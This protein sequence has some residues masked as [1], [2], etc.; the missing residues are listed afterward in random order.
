MILHPWRGL[1]FFTEN[2]TIMSV[3]KHLRATVSQTQYIIKKK[4]QIR[5]VNLT[6]SS[7]WVAVEM[8]G[9]CLWMMTPR[10]VCLHFLFDELTKQ[11]HTRPHTKNDEQWSPH[12]WAWLPESGQWWWRSQA[13]WLNTAHPTPPASIYPSLLPTHSCHLTV[14]HDTLVCVCVCVHIRQRAGSSRGCSG[15]IWGR[16]WGR[17]CTPCRRRDHT[18]TQAW[19][20]CRCRWGKWC[21]PPSACSV[22][23]A[24]PAGGAAPSSLSLDCCLPL[25]GLREKERLCHQT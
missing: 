10:I 7:W 14:S 19:C 20:G 13:D 1:W 18:E 21:A 3:C 23:A 11:V 5:G 2:P 8:T 24:A 15:G 25:F 9:V 12:E 22:T 16:S 17:N 4:N 6:E